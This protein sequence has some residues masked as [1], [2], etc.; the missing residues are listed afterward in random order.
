MSESPEPTTLRF[1][2]AE[3]PAQNRLA[4]WREAIGRR[5]FQFDT[6]P[7]HDGPFHAET[8]AHAMTQLCFGSWSLGN[9]RTAVTHDQL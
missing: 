7:L 1:S 4:I 5:V 2:T 6:M 3:W 9:Q 8:T